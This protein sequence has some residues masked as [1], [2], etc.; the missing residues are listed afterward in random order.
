MSYYALV[1][2]LMAYPIAAA[3]RG[4]LLRGIARMLS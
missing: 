2:L 4:P 1:A 3:L